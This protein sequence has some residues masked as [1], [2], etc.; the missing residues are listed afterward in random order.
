MAV[1][2]CLAKILFPRRGFHR[3]AQIAFRLFPRAPGVPFAAGLTAATPHA[4]PTAAWSSTGLKT[5]V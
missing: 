2:F 1:R 4:F 5:L 3:G